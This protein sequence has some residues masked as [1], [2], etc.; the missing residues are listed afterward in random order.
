MKHFAVIFF[1][2][3]ISCS[4]GKKIVNFD[5]VKQG[6]ELE[7]AYDYSPEKIMDLWLQNVP[8]ESKYNLKKLYED[9]TYTYFGRYFFDKKTKKKKSK[10]F[11]VVTDSLNAHFPQLTEIKGWEIRKQFYKEIVPA[12][13]KKKWKNLKCNSSS[14]SQQYFYRT[15]SP[16]KTE[17]KLIWT[18]R[19][20]TSTIFNKEYNAVYFFEGKKLKKQ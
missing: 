8:H 19:C 3:L 5:K 7:Y 6:K 16:E 13:D 1:I 17:I 14:S 9:T 10:L 12:Q 18:V 15:V 2:L 20:G 11:R 4:P